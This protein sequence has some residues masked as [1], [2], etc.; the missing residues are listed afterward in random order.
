M[1]YNYTFV[2]VTV[3]YNLFNNGENII[4]FIN[5]VTKEVFYTIYHQ[6]VIKFPGSA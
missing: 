4:L 1:K 2:Y 6:V 5:Y 3:K